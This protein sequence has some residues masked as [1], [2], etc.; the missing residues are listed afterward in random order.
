MSEADFERPSTPGLIGDAIKQATALFSAEVSLVRLELT[1][2]LVGALMAVVAI[3]IAAVLM[4]VALIFLLQGLVELL[5]K[6]LAW[7]TFA[8]SFAVGGAILALAAIAVLL[9]L[10]NLSSGRL[11]PSRTLR[12]V[13]GAGELAKGAVS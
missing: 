10:R 2:K 7:P 3:V 1:E 12:E 13:K 4:I 5:V 6:L 11:K 8:A 9:A